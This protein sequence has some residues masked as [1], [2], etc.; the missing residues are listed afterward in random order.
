MPAF[1]RIFASNLASIDAGFI[2]AS[3]QHY[4]NLKV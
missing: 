4:D 2:E 1:F 3:P